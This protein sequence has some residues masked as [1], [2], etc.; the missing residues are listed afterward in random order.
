MT[1]LEDNKYLTIEEYKEDNLLK[2]IWKNTSEVLNSEE[3]RYKWLILLWADVVQNYQPKGVV[4]DIREHSVIIHP[5]MQQWFV[6][7][8][9]PKYRLSGM[10]KLAFIASQDFVSQLSVEQTMRED[11][12]LPFKT[13]YFSCD[14]E[15]FDWVMND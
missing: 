9:F 7:E 5:E 14:T 4:V 12:D 11:N 3:D 8:V 1:L 2:L 6:N 13:Q 10:K 15:G